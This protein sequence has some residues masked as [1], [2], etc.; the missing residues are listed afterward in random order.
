MAYVWHANPN[1]VELK[2]RMYDSKIKLS[3]NKNGGGVI[4]QYVSNIKIWFSTVFF[5]Y[6]HGSLWFTENVHEI[7][8]HNI[9]ISKW[10]CKHYIVN[11]VKGK[12]YE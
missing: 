11:T 1:K 3:I 7:S 6:Y 8:Q 2:C 12:T 10:Q 5:L 9:L 4:A